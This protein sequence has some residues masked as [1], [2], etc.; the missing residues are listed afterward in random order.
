VTFRSK[1]G[2]FWV[3]IYM[4]RRKYNYR[5]LLNLSLIIASGYTC[6]E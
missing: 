1:E 2:N 5:D 6:L 4:R 3:I